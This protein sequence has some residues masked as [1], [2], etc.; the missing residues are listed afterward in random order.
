MDLSNFKEYSLS[1]GLP[2]MTISKSGISFSQTAV[3]RLGKPDYAT[4][5]IDSN[6]RQIIVKPSSQDDPNAAPF[7]K[8]SRKAVSARWNYKDL[9][10]TFEDLMSWKTDIHT[11]RVEGTYFREDNLLL[12]DL[13]QSHQIK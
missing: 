1:N 11:Y 2:T 13:N 9:I 7:Y 3:V 12:F 5:L 6:D 8:E 4:L 10:Q